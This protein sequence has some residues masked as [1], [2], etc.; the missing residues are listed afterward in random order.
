MI[1]YHGSVVVVE[2]PEI[3]KREIGRDFGFAFCTEK[4]LEFLKFESYFDCR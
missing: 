4:S 3:I 2:N 1:L